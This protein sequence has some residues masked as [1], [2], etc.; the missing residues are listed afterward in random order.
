MYTHIN[1]IIEYR[2]WH[3]MTYWI[4]YLRDSSVLNKSPQI[5]WQM[6]AHKKNTIYHT[7]RYSVL[8]FRI[9]MCVHQRMGHFFN[10]MPPVHTRSRHKAF[11]WAQIH[12]FSRPTIHWTRKIYYSHHIF[13]SHR[14]SIAAKNN[15]FKYFAW[16]QHLNTN[17]S[18]S[19]LT[20]HWSRN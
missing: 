7:L 10:Q 19:N 8:N 3:C 17:T 5:L 9:D 11:N 1:T 2:I 18:F 12:L 6:F 14:I 15:S 16:M 20:I 4:L 13:M